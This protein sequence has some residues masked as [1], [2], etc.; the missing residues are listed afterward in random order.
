MKNKIVEIPELLNMVAVYS[1]EIRLS[2]Q[3]ILEDFPDYQKNVFIIMRF[4]STPQL[5]Q[6]SDDL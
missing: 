2:V 1:P 5:I 3:N 4:K 6:I